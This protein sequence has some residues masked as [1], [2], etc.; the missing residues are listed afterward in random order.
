MRF[1]NGWRLPATTL[2]AGFLLGFLDFVWIKFVPSALG[3]LGNSSAVWAVAAFLFAYWV[4]GRW[5]I[6]AA[7][8]LLVVAVPSYYLAAFLIQ[9]DR[10]GALWSPTWTTFGL[11]AGVIFGAAG[12]V[13]RRTD[14]WQIAALAV[15]PAVLFAEALLYAGRLGD[16]SYRVSESLEATLLD[17]GIGI[18]LAL[19]FRAPWPRRG[20]A[21][22]LAVP[23]AAVGYGL[24]RTAGFA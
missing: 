21:L 16:P 18:A 24:F 5:A 4:G 19:L 13:A 3:G 20:A 14:R 1:R 12:V 15:P 8:G 11:I 10:I 23:F 9:H 2:V 17:V 6:P 7:V 22:L